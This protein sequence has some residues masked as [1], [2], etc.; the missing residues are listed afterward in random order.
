MIYRAPAPVVPDAPP[1]EPVREVVTLTVDGRKHEI[2]KP[3]RR[4]RSLA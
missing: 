2:T 3:T 1:P 4:A